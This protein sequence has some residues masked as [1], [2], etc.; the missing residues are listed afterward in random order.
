MFASLSFVLLA[1]AALAQASSGPVLALPHGFSVD[2]AT[3]LPGATSSSLEFSDTGIDAIL[4]PALP[5]GVPDFGAFL[6]GVPVD[7]DALSLGLDW[8]VG[9]A[10][11]EAVVGAGQ[12]AAITFS[13]SRATTG[14]PGS[15]LASAAL[16]P[17][18]AAADVFGYV[19]PGSDLPPVFVGIPFRAQDSRE[20]STYVGGLPGNLDAHDLY[21]ALLYQENPPLAALLPPPTIF[22]SVSAASAPSI[23]MAWT[24]V[25]A[26]RSG[27]TVFSST[28]LPATSTWSTPGVAFAPA[29]FGILP[30]EDLDAL[31]LDLAHG[32]VLFST[33]RALPPPT[34]PRDPI[35]FSVL[36]SGIHWIYRLPGVGTPIS[37]EVGLGLG[38]DDIDGICSLDPGSPA[39]PSQIRLPFLLGTPEP[40]LP[41]TIP[42]ELQASVWRRFDPNLNQEFAETW[43][44]GWPP[45]G[46]PQPSLAIVAGSVN[47]ALGP[48]TV[49]GVFVRPQPGNPFQG[50]PEHFR[51]A[52]PP[53]LSLTGLPLHF[54]WG[55]LSPATFNLSHPI[56]ILL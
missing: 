24:A 4:P 10:I 30:S 41:T 21:I 16:E 20:T 23:P 55:A 56:G 51:I 25:P 49:L 17:D 7:L 40:P 34:G 39:Q 45:P 22:F 38:V 44:T 13:V 29:T 6:A 43:M 35:L 9:N 42:T 46:A 28:W 14:A 50:H 37:A 27:A 33:D 15:L 2:P 47:G 8:V 19:L 11:G 32:L 54:L 12:W 52:I 48:Y 26:L 1:S 53:A 36:G 31:A 5:P 3:A 18:G